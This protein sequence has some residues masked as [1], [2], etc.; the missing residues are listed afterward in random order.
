MDESDFWPCLEYR[1]CGELAGLPDRRLRGLWCDGFIPEH[2]VLDGPSPHII[3]RAWMGSQSQEPWTFTL[4]LDRPVESRERIP[5]SALLPP[6]EVTRWLTIDLTGQ[7]LVIE[8]AVA[9]PD[10]D[11]RAKADPSPTKPNSFVR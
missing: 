7:R 9:V 1:V 4:L 10:A 8:P 2:Y 5:W 11:P 6:P 3:G